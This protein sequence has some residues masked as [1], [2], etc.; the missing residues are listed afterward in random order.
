[1]REKKFT[2]GPWDGTRQ[3]DSCAVTY[4]DGHGDGWRGPEVCT[5]YQNLETN[6]ANAALISAAPDL[7]VAL[8]GIKDRFEHL[9]S[10]STSASDAPFLS[11]LIAI[12]EVQSKEAIAKAYGETNRKATA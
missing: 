11:A 6:K 5:L 10:L 8:E 7:L 9:L 2:K 3:H 4:I 1:M 12:V